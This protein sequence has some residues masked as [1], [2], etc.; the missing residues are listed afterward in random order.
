MLAHSDTGF[1][2]A[3]GFGTGPLSALGLIKSI[4]LPAEPRRGGRADKLNHKFI[5]NRP[6][7]L[8]QG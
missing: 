6:Q 7:F 4:P 5:K 8:R 3:V 1:F 2:L